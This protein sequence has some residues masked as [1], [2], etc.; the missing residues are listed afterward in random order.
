MLS[1]RLKRLE[2]RHFNLRGAE[3]A[4]KK[5]GGSPTEMGPADAQLVTPLSLSAHLQE[6]NLRGAVAT[7]LVT[8]LS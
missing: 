4:Q 3:E 5:R 7:G 2:G 8:F 1:S 6:N